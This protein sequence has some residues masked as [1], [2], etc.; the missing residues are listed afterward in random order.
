MIYTF[1]CFS[2][3]GGCGHLFEQVMSVSEYTDKQTCPQCKKRKCVHRSYVHDRVDGQVRL[4]DSEVKTLGH[5]AERNTSKRSEEELARI[6]YENNKYKFNKSENTPPGMKSVVK[7]EP[8]E[9]GFLPLQRKSKEKMGRARKLAKE[10]A[11]Y[12]KN[13]CDKNV[14]KTAREKKSLLNKK[15]GNK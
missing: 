13:V 5:L 4:A 2:D 15:T 8:D 7:R 11:E 9:K 12:L 3:E 1:E 10:H 6:N 14:R